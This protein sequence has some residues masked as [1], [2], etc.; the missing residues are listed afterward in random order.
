MTAFF[1]SVSETGRSV[2]FVRIGPKWH[3]LNCCHLQPRGRITTIPGYAGVPRQLLT[4][5]YGLEAPDMSNSNTYFGPRDDIPSP[6]DGSISTSGV[7]EVCILFRRV[8]YISV[9]LSRQWLPRHARRSRGRP[10]PITW[11]QM[12]TFPRSISETARA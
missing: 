2:I 6:A 7:T 5:W 1:R 9:I 3:A 10:Q 4:R 8:G 11:S 12:A